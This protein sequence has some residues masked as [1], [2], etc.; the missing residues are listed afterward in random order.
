M[1]LKRKEPF[2]EGSAGRVAGLRPA[3][4]LCEGVGGAWNV[5]TSKCSAVSSGHQP[6]ITLERWIPDNIH[7]WSIYAFWVSELTCNRPCN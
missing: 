4:A 3:A 6:P 7:V 1:A 5:L 2:G